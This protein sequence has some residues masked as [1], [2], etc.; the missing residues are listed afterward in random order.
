MPTVTIAV[1]AALD[2]HAINPM[3]YGTAFAT[4]PQ[5][6]DLNAPYNRSGGNAETTYN[7]QANATN[8]ANDW[9]FESLPESGAGVSGAADQFVSSTLAGGAQPT[10]T[11]PTIGWVAKLGPG[12]THLASFPASVYPNQTGY[13]PYWSQAGNG[14][15]A[16]GPIT[17]NDP[18]LANQPSSPAFE[19]GW[20]QHLVNTFGNSTAGG[21]RYY[22]LDNEPSIWQSTHRDIHPTGAS[23]AEIRDDI[24]NY[25]AMIR[26]VDPNA[27]VVGPEEWGW[28]GYFLSGEDQQ[29]GSTTGNWGNLPDKTANGGWDYLPWVLNQLHTYDRAR[30][31]FPRRV[32]RPLL[33]AGRR[34]QQ[35]RLAGD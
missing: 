18:N 4:T 21:V 5:L 35:R 29:Y 15:T 10:L 24:V 26:S 31:G 6:L 13:D 22:T 28:S 2:L 1:N 16:A 19:Q 27:V 14:M 9:Y 7:W 23:M 8:H 32:Q 25:A 34:V 20:V 3:I 17:G 30:H 11:I 12:G 33:P